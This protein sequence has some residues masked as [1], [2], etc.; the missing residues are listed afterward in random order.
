MQPHK[1][2]KIMTNSNENQTTNYSIKYTK[3]EYRD[4]EIQLNHFKGFKVV[5]LSP[6]NYNGTRLKITDLRSKKS[7]TI[8]RGDEDNYRDDA[9][10]Y[11]TEV[12]K[13]K[14]NGFVSDEVLGF[15]LILT[16]DFST[17]I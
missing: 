2:L 15:Y 12:L 1:N 4:T 9:I 6:T 5:Y 16:D 13:I 8:S 3:N 14:V 11:I 7:I 10:K 17:C